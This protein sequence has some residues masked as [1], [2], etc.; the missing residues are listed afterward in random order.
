MLEPEEGL[1]TFRAE[2]QNT[3]GNAWYSR[4][5]HWPGNL[6]DCKNW[7]SGVTIGR[8][9]DLGKRNEIEVLSDLRLAGLPEKQA[10]KIAAGVKKT[11]CLA[12][13]FVKSHRDD[14]GEITEIQQVRLFKIT[15]ENIKKDSM[16]LYNTYKK[17]GSVSWELMD[18]KIKDVFIDMRLQG[19]LTKDII[20]IFGK[21]VTG[22]I[23]T[24]IGKDSRLMQYEPSRKRIRHLQGN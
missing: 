6:K 17:E 13:E 1:L 10:Q 7:N 5:I 11:R 8:G 22:E 24:M 4:K 3:P 23:I 14:I 18:K 15:Y 2:G 21:N 12:G 20:P 16:R 9:Y 19:Q